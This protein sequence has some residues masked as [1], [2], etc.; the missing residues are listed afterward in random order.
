[1]AKMFSFSPRLKDIRGEN[2]TEPIGE[3]PNEILNSSGSY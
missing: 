3:A 1:M 2:Q